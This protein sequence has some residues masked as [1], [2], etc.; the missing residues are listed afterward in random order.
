MGACDMTASQPEAGFLSVEN[1]PPSV[2]GRLYEWWR[3][4]HWAHSPNAFP[5]RSPN[6]KIAD[7]KESSGHRG[8]GMVFDV[9]DGVSCRP[10]GGMSHYYERH[11][12][13][14]RQYDRAREVT[15]ALR[16]LPDI[17]KAALL[18]RFDVP[19]LERPLSFEQSAERLGLCK[20]TYQRRYDS[21]VKRLAGMMCLEPR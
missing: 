21:A 11:S 17:H 19:K 1:G 16:D 8:K 7:E 13:E 14:L 2:S 10:D 6:G 9:I 4:R 15:K 5:P 12:N 18:A 3:V 20:A